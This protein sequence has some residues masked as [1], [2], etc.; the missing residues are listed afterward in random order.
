MS[1]R[2][3]K[4]YQSA[5]PPA[6]KDAAVKPP[7]LEQLALFVLLALIPIRS[8]INETPTFEVPRLFRD[9]EAS[10]QAHPG[11]TLLFSC[12]ILAI[13]V[14][15]L[16]GRWPLTL[17]AWLPTGGELGFGFLALATIISV[18]LAGQKHL[19]LT[20]GLN[21]LGVIAYGFTLRSLLDSPARVRLTCYV[22]LATGA[23]L[24]TKGAL[25]HFY[26]HPNT[27]A[28]F[29][30]NKAEL[31]KSSTYSPGMLHDYEQRMRSAE[32]SGYYPHSNVYGSNLILL[33]LAALAPVM[34]RWGR[35][36]SRWSLLAP[37]AIFGMLGAIV[38][39]ATGKGPIVGAFAGLSVFVLGVLGRSM[40]ARL[41]GTVLVAGWLIAVGAA[42]GVTYVLNQDEAAL[43]RSI[44]FRH[45]YWRGAAEMVADCGMGGV[46]PLNFGRHFTRYKPV[47]CPEEVES[48]HSWIV[49]LL[50]EWGL[51]GLVGFVVLLIGM[52]W[53]VAYPQGGRS[54][55]EED[56]SG[57]SPQANDCDAQTDSQR[58][59]DALTTQA[60]NI[61]GSTKAQTDSNSAPIN[62]L[63]WGTLFTLV[64]GLLSLALFPAN[65]Y[66]IILFLGLGLLLPLLIGFLLS[67]IETSDDPIISNEPLGYVAIPLFAGAVGF[68]VHTAVDLALFE[69]GPA[70]TCFAMLAAAF[71]AQNMN[72]H[73]SND[74]SMV[75]ERCYPRTGLI[76]GAVVLLTGVS[77]FVTASR[78]Q[79][80]LIKARR[81]PVATRIWRSYMSQPQAQAYA[82]A[83]RTYPL[84]ATAVGE[85]VE[86][87]I[88][89][90][91]TMSQFETAIAEADRHLRRDPFN[92]LGHNLRGTLLRRRYDVSEDIDDLKSAARE[93]EVYVAGYPTNPDRHI[94]LADVLV[95]LA[96]A[97]NQPELR[98]RA[99]NHLRRALEL[100]A[101]RVYVSEPNRK[102]PGDI[103]QIEASIERLQQ[104]FVPTSQSI[105]ARTDRP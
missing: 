59:S 11:F 95:Q 18:S 27:L 84:D 26:E 55:H 16:C 43:G 90:A 39:L 87:M 20:G 45:M 3:L 6:A 70:T 101:R 42:V 35:R 5:P 64:T 31:I 13:G 86:Q 66:L 28:Y 79:H 63:H 53:R 32:L 82:E 76:A 23:V 46:G 78:Y 52:S 7:L 81:N 15:R 24:A 97:A 25:Q 67:A 91:R 83:T 1:R 34:D 102:T 98:D 57:A 100:E 4:Q 47:E 49:Q 103:A 60:T 30:E 8:V 51:L 58:T 22:L 74:P 37:V 33:L 73:K 14:W 41:R 92:D 2:K 40:S 80:A 50:T 56:E 10:Q 77:L 96:G 9:I 93:Y 54:K 99:I 29:E 12:L 104:M 62:L 61:S 69:G 75:A 71:A 94:Y 85:F 65:L 36:V 89:R 72:A 21:L 68:L 19:A 17:R 44:Q 38:F 48:P 88:P 105:S